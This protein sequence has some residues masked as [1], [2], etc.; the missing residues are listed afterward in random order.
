M[1]Q[2]CGAAFA[3]AALAV[4]RNV[5]CSAGSRA[6]MQIYYRGM[7]GAALPDESSGL[8]DNDA[9]NSWR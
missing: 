6:D 2:T 8:S 7:G 4:F 1:E 5:F 9:E 3:A